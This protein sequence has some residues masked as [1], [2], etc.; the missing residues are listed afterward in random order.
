MRNLIIGL[1]LIPAV[2]QAEFMDGNIL[3]HK[4]RSSSVVENM[5]ALGYVQ[6]VFDATQQIT[7][8]APNSIL[9]G[10]VNDL[11]KQ[12]LEHNPALR[13]KTADVLLSDLFRKTWPCVN[14]QRPGV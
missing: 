6:G 12:Y 9:A 13:N 10:Q 1:L 4:Q 14:R 8:C 5:V 7:H 2:A 3:L 11:V